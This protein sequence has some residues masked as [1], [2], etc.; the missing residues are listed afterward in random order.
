MNKELL[1]DNLKTGLYDVLFLKLMENEEVY[2]YQLQHDIEKQSGGLIK[3]FNGSLYAPFNRLMKKGYITSR[4]EFVGKTRFRVY[5]SITDLGREYLKEAQD[6]VENI[7]KGAM[8][9][10]NGGFKSK[11]HNAIDNFLLAINSNAFNNM[12]NVMLSDLLTIRELSN[13]YEKLKEI[14]K[15]LVEYLKFEGFDLFAPARC[16]YL[17]LEEYEL[18][19]EVLKDDK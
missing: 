10:F 14:I 3:I 1:E 13:K 16:G 5:Y 18:L 2:G 9:I 12:D 4:K 11:Y 15:S 7:Y 19:E 6:V 8:M 17:T